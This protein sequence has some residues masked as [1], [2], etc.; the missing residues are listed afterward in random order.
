VK[1]TTIP[2]I[3]II[4]SMIETGDFVGVV[5]GGVVGILGRVRFATTWIVCPPLTTALVEYGA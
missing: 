1:K 4:T 2:P 5:V 3:A